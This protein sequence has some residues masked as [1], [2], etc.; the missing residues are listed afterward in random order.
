MDVKPDNCTFFDF[1]YCTVRRAC[2]TKYVLASAGPINW[3]LLPTGRVAGTHNAITKTW[4]NAHFLPLWNVQQ[5]TRSWLHL[6]CSLWL[7]LL[8]ALISVLMI[9]S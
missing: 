1:L 5:K 9:L 3:G 7:E 8:S 4:L 6:L 2:G